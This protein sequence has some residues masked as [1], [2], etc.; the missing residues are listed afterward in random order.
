[1]KTI[2]TAML[3]SLMIAGCGIQEGPAKDAVKAML[4]DPDSAK[5]EGLQ[6]GITSGD[7]CGYVNAKNRMGGYV[8]KT[9]FYYVKSDKSAGIVQP[10]TDN[11]FKML[12]YDLEY[13]PSSPDSY[14]KVELGC[15]DSAKLKTFCGEAFAAQHQAHPMCDIKAK[16]DALFLYELE[17]RYGK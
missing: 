17:Q 5:F 12:Q 10:L 2:M 13:N 1:M 7:V 4:N 15:E 3:A 11:D 9:P 8:G 16:G 14:V 6:A